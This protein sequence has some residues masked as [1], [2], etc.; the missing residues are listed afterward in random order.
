MSLIGQNSLAGL[1]EGLSRAFGTHASITSPANRFQP[2]FGCC[3]WTSCKLALEP[4][5]RP[6]KPMRN[7]AR[8]VGGLLPSPRGV[9]LRIGTHAEAGTAAAV[10]GR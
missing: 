10:A 4:G 2:S 9:E 7:L 8:R 3:F 6:P 5:E 1:S